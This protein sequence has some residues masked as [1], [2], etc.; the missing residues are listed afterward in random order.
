MRFSDNDKKVISMAC[1]GDSDL[2]WLEENID[3][4]MYIKMLDRNI[5]IVNNALCKDIGYFKNIN[6]DSA[7]V[8][9][10]MIEFC[11]RFLYNGIKLIEV[12]EILSQNNIHGNA[13]KDVKENTTIVYPIS[14]IRFRE[15]F[16]I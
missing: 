13:Y 15:T 5:F 16:D 14:N 2:S 4:N 11:L 7:F 6:F 12:E 9:Y 1:D 8:H 10:T 3:R